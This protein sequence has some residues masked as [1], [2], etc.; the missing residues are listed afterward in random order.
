MPPHEAP[1]LVDPFRTETTPSTIV[2]KER[3][4]TNTPAPQLVEAVMPSMYLAVEPVYGSLRPHPR[5]QALMRA[6]GLR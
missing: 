2:P 4:L 5:F 6:A 3:A 1:A